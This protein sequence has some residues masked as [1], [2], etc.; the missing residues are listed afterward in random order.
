MPQAAGQPRLET[1]RIAL[2]GFAQVMHHGLGRLQLAFHIGRGLVQQ[3]DSTGQ[4]D[5][6]EKGTNPEVDAPEG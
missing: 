5:Q 6:G 3:Q 2:G 1:G 4:G